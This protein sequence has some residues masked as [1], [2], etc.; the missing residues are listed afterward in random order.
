VQ[1]TSSAI[2]FLRHWEPGHRPTRA[3]TGMR[4]LCKLHGVVNSTQ[5][6]TDL[7]QAW[8]N[9]DEK[10]LE[11]LTPPV[12]QEL[13]RMAHQL[14]ASE[15][16]GHML[17]TTA[18]INEAYLRLIDWRNVQWQNRA[19]FFATCAGMMRRILVDFARSRDYAKRGAGVT[20]ISLDEAANVSPD[21]SPQIVAIHEALERLEL[22]DPRK[23]RV[24]E[25][26]VFGGL[27]VNEVAEVLQVSRRTVIN[28]W[29]FAKAWLYRE[30][31]GQP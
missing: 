3:S 13:H 17:Q 27:E 29:N 8:S 9:G 18:L 25:L 11:K 31:S 7:L 6:L 21:R 4:S 10:A 2:D 1:R 30:I 24:V 16:P 22:T 20:M 12:Y 5:E 14:M 28:D 19:H 26:R 15:R 23:G